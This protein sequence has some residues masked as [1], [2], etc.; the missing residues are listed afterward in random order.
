MCQ[1]HVSLLEEGEELASLM[2]YPYKC[3]LQ[4]PKEYSQIR[5]AEED[6]EKTRFHTEE[7]VY[8]FI[9]MPKELKKSATTLQRMM[10]KVLADQRGH[11]MEIYLEEIVIKSNSDPDL[12]QDVKNT[13]GAF[14]SSKFK[15]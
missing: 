3:F 8:C 12:V 15:T 10:E 7:G 6:E 4:L 2:G 9:H 14:G 11:N 1:G 5:M 13:K